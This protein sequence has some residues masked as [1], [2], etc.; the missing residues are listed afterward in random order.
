[1]PQTEQQDLPAVNVSDACAVAASPLRSDAWLPIATAVLAEIRP[2]QWAKNL[3]VFVPLLV[4]HRAFEPS[5]L[6]A[7]GLAFMAWSFCASAVYVVNDLLDLNADRSHPIKQAR[8]LASG[9]LPAKYAPA[10]IGGLLVLTAV[11]L[12]A[13]RNPLLAAA[14]VGYACTTVAYSVWLKRLAFVDVLVLA[15]LYALRLVGGGVATDIVL[16]EWLLVFSGFLF[17]SLALAKRYSELLR[18]RSEGCDQA[19]GRGYRTDDISLVETF[20]IGCGL[21]STVVFAL[22]I[23]SPQSRLLYAH[24][25]WLWAVCPLLLYWNM[26]LWLVARQGRLMEDPVLF[27]VSDSISRWLG[28]AVVG[29]VVAATGSTPMSTAI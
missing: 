21:M 13:S 3:L 27:A 22:Y 8:P 23:N 20:G 25:A 26:R 16:S 2:R 5:L 18:V 17:A 1:M 10:L 29:L 28:V 19:L 6:W 14:L 11:C 7:A 15:G 12:T 9:A 4:S 24:P